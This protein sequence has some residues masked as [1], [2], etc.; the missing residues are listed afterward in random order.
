MVMKIQE[1]HNV[2]RVNTIKNLLL[3]LVPHFLSLPFLV[4]FTLVLQMLLVLCILLIY[5][6]A[7]LKVIYNVTLIP[8]Y[9]YH[10]HLNNVEAEKAKQCLLMGQ[11]VLNDNTRPANVI[12]QGKYNT[13][14]LQN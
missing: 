9:T 10:L 6:K 8:L 7:H 5:L 11:R 13:C 3:P 2:P 4:I 12:N 1:A 14:L